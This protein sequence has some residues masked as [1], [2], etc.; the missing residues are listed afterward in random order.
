MDK[1]TTT[2]MGSALMEANSTADYCD[3]GTDCADCGDRYDQDE[4][5]IDREE[6]CDDSDFSVGSKGFQK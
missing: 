4:D 3:L 6:D 5:G 1:Y 2:Q